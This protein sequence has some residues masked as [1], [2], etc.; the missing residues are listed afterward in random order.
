MKTYQNSLLSMGTRFNILLPGI[1][2]RI[3]DEIFDSVAN[4][5][6]RIEKMLSCFIAGSDI[7]NINQNA[8]KNP[9]PV[10]GEVFGILTECIEFYKLTE[11]NFDIG[12]G[13]I[14]D[15]WSGNHTELDQ[16][17]DINLAGVK[18]IN[19]D[20]SDSSVRFATNQVKINLGGYGKGY[21][22]QN[23][24]K[25]LKESGI[26]NAYVS[27]GE[28]SVSCLGKHPFGDYWPVGIQ[29]FYQKEKSL[30]TFQVVDG[31][32]STSGNLQNNHIISPAT[33][34]PV[35][36]KRI[37]SVKSPSPVIA[38]VLST[39][40]MATSD[41]QITKILESFPEEEVVRVEYDNN[42]T[43]ICKFK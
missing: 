30:T 25:L 43:D 24:Q 35:T 28:S 16:E 37:V 5:L 41:E 38:E 19:L 31:S 14:I 26:E 40:L 17:P 21:A 11:N 7:S 6:M 18:N 3:G 10:N 27:F 15:Y 32:V 2:E 33:G 13:Y 4:E 42:K 9:V 12:L 23:I 8:F 1:D 36:K 22:L 39:A 29:D 34:E 20:K